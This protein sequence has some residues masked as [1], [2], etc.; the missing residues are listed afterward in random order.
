[1]E[2][3]GRMDVFLSSHLNICNDFDSL[4]YGEFIYIFQYVEISAG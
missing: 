3:K 2:L 1:M 4:P